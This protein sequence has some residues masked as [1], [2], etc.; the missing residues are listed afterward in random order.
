M[1]IKKIFNLKNKVVI[2]TGTNGQLGKLLAKFYITNGAIVYG[3]DLKIQKKV[4]D[5]NYIKCNIN[6]EKQLE[7]AL[8]KIYEKS[9]KIN[10]LVNNAAV[11]FFSNFNNRTKEEFLNTIITNL[12][13][14]FNLIRKVS[15]KAKLKDNLRI[16]NISSIYGN[17]SPNF[18]IYSKNDRINSEVYGASKAGLQQITKYFANIFAK[19]NITINCIS[20]G[21]I[22]NKRKQNPNFIKRYTNNVPKNRMAK[23]EDFLS[24]IAFLSS[25][26][27][28]YFTG[29]NLIVDGGLTL[30]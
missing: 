18:D 8:K 30:K 22:I 28:G 10:V 7:I 16:I 14:P 26:N 19:K 21:G 9:K 24:A 6:D 13:S 4:K 2:I 20:P 1:K 25:V 17:I 27:S 15:K 29:Q 11:S 5:L 3:L 12:Y 23:P